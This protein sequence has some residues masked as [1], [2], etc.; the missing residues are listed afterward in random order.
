MQPK[1]TLTLAVLVGLCLAS[2]CKGRDLTPGEAQAKRVDEAQEK[3]RLDAI[4]DIYEDWRY[5]YV[6]YRTALT[7]ALAVKPVPR[8]ENQ[9][10]RSVEELLRESQPETDPTVQAL[11]ADWLAT[12]EKYNLRLRQLQNDPQRDPRS[13]LLPEVREELM[14]PR[15]KR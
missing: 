6:T 15:S 4:D 5:D 13:P 2:G 14:A 1:L 10:V 9:P 12:S 3:A 11:N 8:G 7:N